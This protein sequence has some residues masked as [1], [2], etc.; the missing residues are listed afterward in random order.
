MGYRWDTDDGYR[1][2]IEAAYYTCSLIH[3]SQ[4]TSDTGGILN[5]ILYIYP[6][7]TTLSSCSVITVTTMEGHHVALLVP[8][9]QERCWPAWHSWQQALDRQ[10]RSR[11]AHCPSR[12]RWPA[13]LACACGQA[14][15]PEGV[16]QKCSFSQKFKTQFQPEIQ[17]VREK[18]F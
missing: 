18:P 10:L 16:G 9:L 14:H 15:V 5:S 4:T 17:R 3:V 1:W 8:P 13:R 6:H 11:P 12:H 2:S 7:T